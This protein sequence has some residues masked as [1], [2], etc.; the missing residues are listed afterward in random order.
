MLE[1]PGAGKATRSGQEQPKARQEQPG[2]GRHSQEQPRAGQTS[3]EKPRAARATML[4]LDIGR[5]QPGSSS[6]GTRSS[7]EQARQLEVARVCTQGCVEEGV[8]PSPPP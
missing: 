2:Q 7:Q 1:E 6:Q 8:A 4:Q 3:Q 5:T